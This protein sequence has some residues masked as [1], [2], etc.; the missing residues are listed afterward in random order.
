MKKYLFI[1]AA[2]SMMLL[3][4]SKGVDAPEENESYEAF[5]FTACGCGCDELEDGFTWPKEYSIW[6]YPVRWWIEE[7]WIGSAGRHPIEEY[8][9]PEDILFSLSTEDLAELC[10][11]FPILGLLGENW[12]YSVDACFDEFNGLRELFQRK[13]AADVLLKLYQDRMRN[14]SFVCGLD[15]TNPNLRFQVFFLI[16]FYNI[17][18]LLSRPFLQDDINYR[19]ILQTLVVSYEE[20]GKYLNI[21]FYENYF[22]RAH[23]IIRISPQSIDLFPLREN[24][25]VFKKASGVDQQTK[26][27]INELSYQ[28]IK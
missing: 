1:F 13:G 5:T 27:L 15:Q 28:L 22:A 14:Y 4:C 18:L 7:E 10:V 9:I 11:A 25:L 19:K 23:L 17:E 26:D 16:H 6:Y 2:C 12:N 8:Q 21:G 3:S 20:L 24:N